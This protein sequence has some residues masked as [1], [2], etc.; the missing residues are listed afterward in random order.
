MAN[1]TETITDKTTLK[2]GV[3]QSQLIKQTN[4]NFQYVVNEISALQNDVDKRLA[5]VQEIATDRSDKIYTYKSL[6]YFIMYFGDPNG[7]KDRD[8]NKITEEIRLG[9]EIL[10]DDDSS[11]DFWISGFSTNYTNRNPQDDKNEQGDN[12]PQP[13]NCYYGVT[14]AKESAYGNID[15]TSP[16]S[17]HKGTNYCI[18][19]N[20][21]GEVGSGGSSIIYEPTNYVFRVSN[22]KDIQLNDYQRKD[23]IYETSDEDPLRNPVDGNE[24]DEYQYPSMNEFAKWVYPLDKDKMDKSQMFGTKK[25]YYSP[26]NDRLWENRVNKSTFIIKAAPSSE[27]NYTDDSIF[28]V[29][30]FATFWNEFVT[31]RVTDG[32]IDIY[33]FTDS[34]TALSNS[35]AYW[36]MDGKNVVRSTRNG[37]E[38]NCLVV[39][40]GVDRET[41]K[42]I[43]VYDDNYTPIFYEVEN[44]GSGSS[45]VLR[46][47]FAEYSE[48][49]EKYGRKSGYV[50]MLIRD[51]HTQNI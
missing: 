15:Y 48:S 27:Y 14:L 37:V 34:D 39:A 42:C 46:V 17:Y 5:K 43:G 36:Q 44:I 38:Y 20:A 23:N 21:G 40:S 8:G 18:Y 26:Q 19:Y 25:G 31:R 11:P 7:P 24:Y 33:R 45:G 32:K 51:T 50:L 28:T 41:Y 4:D 13:D 6:L 35:F 30:Q 22:T 16:N 9:T 49:A 12:N 2:L 3:T 47:L 1:T 29:G 10:I